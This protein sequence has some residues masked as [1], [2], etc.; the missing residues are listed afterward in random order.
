MSEELYTADEIAHNYTVMGHSVG[1][2]NQLI[3]GT[4]RSDYTTEQK[5]N[6]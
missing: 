4:A 1:L 2:I 6:V 5:K 3:A